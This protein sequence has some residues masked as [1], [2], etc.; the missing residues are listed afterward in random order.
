MSSLEP[1]FRRAIKKANEIMETSNAGLQV[2]GVT[3]LTNA[4]SQYTAFLEAWGRKQKT[5]DE[6]NI[7][8]E[9]VH[10]SFF[11]ITVEL[12]EFIEWCKENKHE[13]VVRLFEKFKKIKGLEKEKKLE[14]KKDAELLKQPLYEL[15]NEPAPV[16]IEVIIGD[17][18]GQTKT[19][20]KK[21]CKCNEG[22]YYC[23]FCKMYHKKGTQ[24]FNAIVRMKER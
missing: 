20:E 19:I 8:N 21:P 6:L 5:P 13:N 11:S 4:I 2:K 1:Y 3:A 22:E 14:E 9:N 18:E 24:C 12:D 17:V 15:V 23:S 16:P 10:I 7:S